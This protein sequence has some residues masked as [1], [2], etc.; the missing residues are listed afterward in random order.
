MTIRGPLLLIILTL[1]SPCAEARWM[2]LRT[3]NFELYTDSTESRAREVLSELEQFRNVFETQ[4][5]R[6]NVSPLPVRVFLFH[7]EASFRP[8]QVRD[9]SSGYYRGG[10]DGDYIAMR[11]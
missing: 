2:R 3:P 10:P 5:P 9:S 8:F 7:S 6:R 4:S 11:A 1:V